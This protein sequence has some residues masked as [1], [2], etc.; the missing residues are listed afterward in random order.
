MKGWVYIISNKAMPDIVKVG[1]SNK[2]PCGRA[3]E[4]GTGAP[5]PYQVEYEIIV[6]HPRKVEQS[7]HIILASVNEGK[8]WFRCDVPTAINAIKQACNGYTIYSEQNTSYEKLKKHIQE[9]IDYLQDNS[10][11]ILERRKI[12]RT[13][14]EHIS[15][16]EKHKQ[17]S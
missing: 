6:E 1:Y 13:I 14:L 17:D 5:H 10:L 3:N 8:E 4:L 7:A 15:L 16:L 2:D 11:G 9:D 12:K